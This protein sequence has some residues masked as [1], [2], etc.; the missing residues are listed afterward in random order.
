MVVGDAAMI[1][2][3]VGREA[4]A[5]IRTGFEVTLFTVGE[6]KHRSETRLG[7]VD[8]VR[9]AV[10]YTLTEARRQS[11]ARRRARVSGLRDSVGAGAGVGWG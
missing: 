1:K 9:V 5:L 2:G 7:A 10:P 4:L 3:R 8:V 6:A 11:R